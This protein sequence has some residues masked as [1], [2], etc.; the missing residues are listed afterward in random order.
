M[1]TFEDLKKGLELSL[2]PEAAK[3]IQATIQIIIQ[4]LP[5]ILQFS[6]H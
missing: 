1:A 3:G 5:K 6:S 4:D 2:E